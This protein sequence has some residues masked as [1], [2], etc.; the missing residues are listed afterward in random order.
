MISE[1]AQWAE[2]CHIRAKKFSLKISTLKFFLF[3]SFFLCYL[4][5]NKQTIL[6]SM[7]LNTGQQII[8]SFPSFPFFVTVFTQPSSMLREWLADVNIL[9]NRSNSRTMLIVNTMGNNKY[10]GSVDI[11]NCRLVGRRLEKDNNLKLNDGTLLPHYFQLIAGYHR[12]TQRY[13]V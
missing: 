10:S 6:T 8:I 3:V 13:V 5:F 1:V 9:L 12:C 4:C 11:S 7:Q 2:T